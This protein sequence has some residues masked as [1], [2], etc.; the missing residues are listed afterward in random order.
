MYVLIWSFD[1]SDK[2][3]VLKS[4][5]Y[6]LGRPDYQDLEKLG[7]DFSSLD[8]LIF[9][10]EDYS[11]KEFTGFRSLVVS[12]R[13]ALFYKRRNGNRV[14]L[15]IRDHGSRGT[16]SKNGTLV[17]E[18]TLPK[19]G[20]AVVREGDTI[21]LSTLGPIFLIGVQREEQTEIS[22]SADVPVEV[23][24][25][26]AQ[27]LVEK[28]VALDHFRVGNRSFVVVRGAGTVDLGRD[29]LVNIVNESLDK[30]ILKVILH[31]KA[32]LIRVKDSIREGREEDA[33]YSLEALK[34]LLKS[35]FYKHFFEKI[36]AENLIDDIYNEVI[37]LID[38]GVPID[39]IAN[40]VEIYIRALEN[41]ERIIL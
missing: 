24:T 27:R 22:L 20:E 40:K 7:G 10:P 37:K 9:N 30:K 34:E 28:N 4:D 35:G 21:R 14:E 16:G 12:R 6:F 1:D 25:Q 2:R 3:F 13:H 33:K 32:E 36:G 18:K 38:H 31:T 26:I 41:L 15:V 23:P 29:L 39:S 8:V 11:E 19:G 17:N 5:R